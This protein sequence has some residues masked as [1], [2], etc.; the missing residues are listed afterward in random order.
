MRFTPSESNECVHNGGHCCCF[1]RWSQ[2][3]NHGGC[4]GRIELL[5]KASDAVLRV[6]V[7]CKG[8]GIAEQGLVFCVSFGKKCVPVQPHGV[9]LE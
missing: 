3:Q 5:L 2:G 7:G 1:F 9:A 4:S 6:K 8:P